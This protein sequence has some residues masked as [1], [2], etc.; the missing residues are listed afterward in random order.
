MIQ[1][2]SASSANGVTWGFLGN[3]L[4]PPP[5]SEFPSVLLFTSPQSWGSVPATVIDGGL[6]ATEELPTPL[7]RDLNL[8]QVVDKLDIDTMRDAVLADTSN[9]IFNVDRL[10]GNVPDVDDF[11][12]LI[13]DIIGTGRGDGNLDF[14]INFEDFVFVSN[15]F[16]ATNTL[17]MQG[18]YNL[19]TVTNFED[20]VEVANQF[21][22][23]FSSGGAV[24]EPTALVLLCVGALLGARRWDGMTGCEKDDAGCWMFDMRYS[25]P[26]RSES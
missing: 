7:P 14:I 8:G 2:S 24:P 3:T 20:F 21:G 12:F 18:N 19:D 5:A 17:W 22:A 10:G 26:K 6:S 1:A 15:N 13:S 11:D 25:M 16:G 9:A 4:D 23:V